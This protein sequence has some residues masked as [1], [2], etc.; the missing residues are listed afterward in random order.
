MRYHVLATDYDGTLAAHGVVDADTLSALQ[1][2]KRSGRKLVLVTGRELDDLFRVFPDGELFDRIV[3]EN[4]AVLHCPADHRTRLLG[5][6]PAPALVRALKERGVSPLSVGQVIVATWE[7]NETVVLETIR[8]LGLELQVIFNKGAVMVL[9]SGVNKATGLSAALEDLG[10]SAHNAVS[11]GDA[12]NDHAFLAIS[13]CAV[14]VENALPMLKQRADL[15]LARARGAGVSELIDALL[16]SDLAELGPSLVRHRLDLGR[17]ANDALLGLAPYGVSLMIAGLSGSGKSTLASALLEQLTT[18]G[19]QFCLVDPEGDHAGTEEAIALGDS[20]HAPAISE[21]LD[22]LS[23]P[24]A[25]A[26]VGLLGLPLPDRPAFFDD[27]LTH[28]TA[29]RARTGRPHWLIL[30]EAH[31]LVPPAWKPELSANHALGTSLLITVHP[32]R[33]APAVLAEIDLMIAVGEQASQSVQAF[34]TAIGAPDPAPARPDPGEALA[35]FPREARP[36]IAFR[37]EQPRGERLR[38]QRKYASGTLG[39][40]KSFYFRGPEDKLKLRAQNLELFL[41]IAEGVD[42]ATWLHHLRAGDYSAWLR[43]AIKDQ[44]L[45]DEV[46]AIEAAKRSAAESLAAV[47]DAIRRRYT[48]SA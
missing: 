17:D 19:Y 45:A 8:D 6:P 26:V 18:R 27:L 25:S 5:E 21:V 46:G 13:E 15:V 22:V 38:H 29:L 34:A 41:Q 30:D 39:P 36:P 7:P 1:R 35:W 10:L 2:F 11:V 4:G 20:Q 42:E 43:E 24:S 16:V 44:E 28:L 9:P 23:H 32:E 33:I 14:A 40:D 47:G 31:H 3:A 12:E 48:G 37:P